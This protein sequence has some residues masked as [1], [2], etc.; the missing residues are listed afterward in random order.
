VIETP[1]VLLIDD[2]PADVALITEA[3][4][5]GKY[6]SQFH[7]V[8]DGESAIAY[9][10]SLG[11]DTES[12][13]PDLVILDLNLPK[14]EGEK[15]LAQFKADPGCRQIPVVVFSSSQSSQEIAR[16]Y[17]LGANCYV[18]K[19]G[20]LAGFVAAV[21]SIEEFWFGSASLPDRIDQQD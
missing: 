14:V 1:R 2:N 20:D 6:R 13:R 19:A 3:S 18:R 11:Q 8:V 4:A 17:E 9:L 15:V 7:H 10:R 16:C 5:R 12:V 21:R